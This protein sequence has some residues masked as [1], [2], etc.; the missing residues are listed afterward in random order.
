MSM[1]NAECMIIAEAGNNHEGRLDVALELVERAKE[2]GADLV[3]FQAGTA[4]GFARNPTDGNEVARYRKYELGKAGYDSLI[5]HGLLHAIP[6]FFSVWGE[7]FDEYHGLQYRKV[8]AR[9]CNAETIKRLDSPTTFISIPHVMTLKAASM[10][11][12]EKGIPMHVVAEYPASS[13]ML[14]RM[15]DLRAT[16]K[17]RIGE[18]GYS[19]HT[20]G[21]YWPVRVATDAHL[22]ARAIEKHFTLKHD[23][24]PLRDHALSA[25]PK[26]MKEMVERIKT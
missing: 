23:F 12:I 10:L 19:D 26:E 25:T 7:G 1:K 2:A 4:E 13:A 16:L 14:T 15:A 3:K 6:V 21:I 8:P 9:Q 5:R 22:R 17:R 24:G 11:P 20:V 18:V